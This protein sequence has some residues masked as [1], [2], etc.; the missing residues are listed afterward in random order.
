[1]TDKV[2]K[3]I[4]IKVNKSTSLKKDPSNSP[5]G[6]RYVADISTL[7]SLLTQEEKDFILTFDE[8]EKQ[9][10]LYG[11]LKPLQKM[12]VERDIDPLLTTIT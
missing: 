3:S 6:I 5:V 9:G 8:E 2:P 10:L 11:I 4:N 7:Y 1:M 12:I